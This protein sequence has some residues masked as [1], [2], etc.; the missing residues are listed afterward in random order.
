MNLNTVAGLDTAGTLGVTDETT[1]GGSMITV[2]EMYYAS[3]GPRVIG[4]LMIL[5]GAFWWAFMLVPLWPGLLSMMMAVV[6]ATGTAL[7]TFLVVFT[8]R[9]GIRLR[10]Y[11][12]THS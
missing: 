7:G 2:E 11:L 5:C 9:T 1:S 10:L 8:S 3:R 12:Y 4:R 6:A